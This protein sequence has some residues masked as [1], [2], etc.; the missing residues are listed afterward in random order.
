MKNG[1]KYE[2]SSRPAS[3]NKLQQKVQNQKY[4]MNSPKEI[5]MK[6]GFLIEK[7]ITSKNLFSEIKVNRTK[8]HLPKLPMQ[9]S[10]TN[11]LPKTIQK[12]KL[13]VI[14]LKNKKHQNDKE[15]SECSDLNSIDKHSNTNINFGYNR[16]KIEINCLIKEMQHKNINNNFD[17]NNEQKQDKQKL[18][19]LRKY[20]FSKNN[21]KSNDKIIISDNHKKKV[22]ES[23]S[24]LLVKINKEIKDMKEINK[25]NIN[26][27]NQIKKKIIQKKKKL[28]K[29]KKMN[30]RRK[31]NIQKK[32]M[33]MKKKIKRKK[34]EKK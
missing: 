5:N 6:E 22:K 4:Y 11:P 34:K 21:N 13:P 32:M 8:N 28:K 3:A 17:N 29:E 10:I 14:N 15:D 19:V 12:K 31:E 18:N 30:I 25:T 27:I 1:K 7:T 20:S 23:S 9:N 24:D 16:N 2:I 26:N 33:M